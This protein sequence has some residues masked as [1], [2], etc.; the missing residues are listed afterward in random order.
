MNIE[1]KRVTKAFI[2]V[3]YCDQS[4]HPLTNFIYLLNSHFIITVIW[5]ISK[6][7]QL[8]F[9]IKLYLSIFIN[10]SLLASWKVFEGP[11]W[12]L[13][14]E[15]V[16]HFVGVTKNSK[17]PKKYEKSKNLKNV[18]FIFWK[19]MTLW[20]IFHQTLQKHLISNTNKIV[21]ATR[22]TA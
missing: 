8:W 14:H 12:A 6:F 13:Y 1:D 5:S 15:R 17:L 18:Y 4:D 22:P 19:F 11:I 3:G 16:K 20:K 2:L 21:A 9:K 10:P 7:I